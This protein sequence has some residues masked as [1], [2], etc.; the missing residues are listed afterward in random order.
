MAAR[1]ARTLVL[2]LAMTLSAAAVADETASPR[3]AGEAAAEASAAA[4]PLRIVVMD[5]LCL[6]LACDCVAGY[7][8]RNYGRLA[9]HLQRRL[10]RAVELVY[11]ESLL[12]PHART[13]DGVDLVIGKFSE[14]VSDAERIGL[15][16]RSLAMLSGKDGRITQTGLFVTRGDDKAT[17][18]PEL[19]DYR[20]LF[21]PEDAVEKQA[22]A[23][24][25]LEAFDLA[26][27]EP[28]AVSPGCTTAAIAV[29]E[30]DADAAV[31]SSYAM[32]L[33]EGCGT[34]AKG[35][36]KIVG[37]TDPVPFVGVFA[38]DRVDAACEK[39]LAAALAGVAQDA[40]LL[41][42]LESR[43]GFVRLPPIAADG[44]PKG[45][46]ADWRGPNRDA[47]S[48]DVPQ[49][50]PA[51][52]RLLWSRVLTGPGMAG[53][54][55]VGGHGGRGRKR[56]SGAC[57]LV[58]DKSLDQQ[59][60]VFRC[61]DADTGTQLWKL[62]YPAPGEMDFTNSPRATP[63]V[64]RR[65]VYLLGAFGHLHCV[66]L[67]TGRIVWKRNLAED[68]GVKAPTW[69]YCSSPLVVDDKLVVN[70]GA[71][72]ASLAALDLQSGDVLWATPGDPPGYAGFILAELGGLRQIV[73]YDCVSLG[74]WDPQS[75][76]RLWTLLPEVEG[77][78]NVPTP[79]AVGGKLLVS[80]ENNGTRL[81][82]F[83]DQG[84]IRPEPIAQSEDLA[85]DTSTPV[86]HGGLVFGNY[87]GL[88]CLDLE[89]GLATLWETELDPFVDYCSLIAGNG[90]VLVASQSGK[91][92]L[93]EAAAK[94]FTKISEWDLFG[95][96]PATDR[97]VWSHPAL[98]GNRLYIRNLLAVYCFVLE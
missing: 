29:V 9:E 40:E 78:F 48:A 32:P 93:L 41:A 68:F 19:G 5:P 97:D 50:L 35:E 75:G 30:N 22:A 37:R 81:Y 4:S 73:G 21:G 17:A 8:Q 91:L 10:A 43:D 74:G 12:E 13:G 92:S 25:S 61:L 51:E 67:D 63:V 72:D 45:Q 85:P 31:I 58:T 70:P 94:G 24:A 33:L 65:L 95:D 46:W 86:V 52:K 11:A 64:D 47:V 49:K 71:V 80:T 59:N 14:V 26:V 77:D 82:A 55:V 27:P 54:A 36:L 96:V 2:V 90:R 34:I 15:V 28:A 56:G 66:R 7:A 83:D 53:V 16:V 20:I 89:G 44:D 98:L 3:T 1:A 79:I 38:S 69:G 57:L 18:I 60:D 87:G 6:E 39:A 84:R 42:A 62:E 76:K 88:V 23:V